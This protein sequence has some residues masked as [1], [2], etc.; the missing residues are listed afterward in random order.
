MV[1]L[2]GSTNLSTCNPPLIAMGMGR[3]KSLAAVTART[4]LDIT[5]AA[6]QRYAISRSRLVTGLEAM[7]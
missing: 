7:V 2:G 3:L 5:T 4:R 6:G 1:T